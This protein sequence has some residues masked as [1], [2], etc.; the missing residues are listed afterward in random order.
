MGSEEAKYFIALLKYFYET[1]HLHRPNADAN[2][3]K[4]ILQ[5]RSVGDADDVLKEMI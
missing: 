4:R 5:L 1:R 2:D 3:I